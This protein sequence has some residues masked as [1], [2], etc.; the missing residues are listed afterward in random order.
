MSREGEISLGGGAGRGSS[1]RNDY[2]DLLRGVAIIA[3]VLGHWLLTAIQYRNGQFDGVD[4]IAFVSFGP[5]VTLV[6]QM[7]PIFFLVGGYANALSWSRRRAAGG[8][9]TGWLQLR[10]RRLLGPTS[11]Y[12]AIVAVAIALA[13]AAGVGA[14][15]LSQ[16]AWA[17]TFHLWFLAAY[18]VLLAATPAL[19]V[20]HLRLGWAVPVVMGVAA[21]VISAVVV[22]WRWPLIGWANYVLVWGTFHQLGFAWH[23]GAF[24][25][26]RGRAVALAV[27]AGAALVALIG[28]GGFPVSMVGFPGARIQNPSPPSMALLAF[29]LTQAGI[30]LAAE[31]LV[32]RR[33]ARRP[34]GRAFARPPIGR[35]FARRGAALSMPIYLWH[36]VPVVVVAVIA[37]PLGWLGQPPIGSG[38][39][40]V[41]HVVWIGVL[42]LALAAVLLIVAMLR[43][44]WLQFTK[45]WPTPPV[46]DRPGVGRV[47]RAGALPVLIGVSLVC[48]A[49]GRLAVQ[50]LAPNGR[51]GVTT[52]AAYAVGAV[53]AVAR[54]PRRRRV[55]SGTSTVVVRWWSPDRAGGRRAP[56]SLSDAR[57]PTPRR[58]RRGSIR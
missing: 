27:I 18:G 35:G 49:L 43:R 9:W 29:G 23:D 25:G 17:F 8:R 50:G 36:M 31:P 55:P 42:A 37:Y 38:R 45:R 39:W 13:Q 15:N 3:V 14:G 44:G 54:W 47:A 30:V 7:V 19:Y 22:Q 48:A 24:R 28:W 56:S 2:V 1:G 34:A 12:L 6:L 58:Y 41:Q 16:A 10:L 26:R 33:L 53:L 52:L 46:V 51:V 5:W 20:A 57:R 11:I 32:S 4:A 40:W 21:V